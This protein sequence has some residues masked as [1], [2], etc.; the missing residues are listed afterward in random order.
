MPTRCD[1]EFF[2]RFLA[3]RSPVRPFVRSSANALKNMYKN[4][5]RRLGVVEYPWISCREKFAR[6][7]TASNRSHRRRRRCHRRR[8]RRR[9]SSSSSSSSVVVVVVVVVRCRRRRRH[10]N[11]IQINSTQFTSRMTWMSSGRRRGGGQ[12]KIGRF[13]FFRPKSFLAENNFHG[14]VFWPQQIFWEN[15]IVRA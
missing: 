11:S 14:K 15:F 3:T 12:K 5:D 10:S 2:P 6:A 9:S 8:R 13:F 1:I 7:M 4:C